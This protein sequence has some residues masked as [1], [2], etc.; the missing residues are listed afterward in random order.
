MG[1]SVHIRAT[2]RGS[3]V[4]KEDHEAVRHPV[5]HSRPTNSA[6]RP[7]NSQTPLP[8][9]LTAPVCSTVEAQTRARP[10]ATP[11]PALD[12]HSLRASTSPRPL[13][14]TGDNTPRR[15]S[16]LTL[17][18]H[19]P[20]CLE[21]RQ[22]CAPSFPAR[23]GLPRL[24]AFS[25]IQCSGCCGEP[26]ASSQASDS[27]SSFCSAGRW[28]RTFSWRFWLLLRLVVGLSRRRAPPGSR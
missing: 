5:L 21:T 11:G 25:T 24:A 12:Y 18:A 14:T 19:L 27:I 13:T 1:S 7:A 20:A 6:V 10:A 28:L 9:R 23:S 26:R 4:L 22:G 15:F 8:V 16:G 3:T 2:L 17:Y